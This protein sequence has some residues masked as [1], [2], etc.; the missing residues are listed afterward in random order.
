[1]IA[2]VNPGPHGLRKPRSHLRGAG[3]ERWRAVQTA[4]A[5]IALGHSR[6]ESVLDAAVVAR[7]A[8]VDRRSSG[9]W[10]AA[11][12]CYCCAIGAATIAQAID[13]RL[14]FVTG[15]RRSRAGWVVSA[16]PG[17]SRARCLRLHTRLT[18]RPADR[19]C[20]GGSVRGR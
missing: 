2:N 20:A 1:M 7:M 13:R 9:H 11:M 16:R 18:T 19:R 6:G 17:P 15:R 8:D 10:E 4:A 14:A 5:S 12:S 3:R